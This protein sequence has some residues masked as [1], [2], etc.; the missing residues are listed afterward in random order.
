MY[1]VVFNL[2]TTCITKLLN[3]VNSKIPLQ[4]INISAS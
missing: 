2:T 1:Y 4:K 3:V